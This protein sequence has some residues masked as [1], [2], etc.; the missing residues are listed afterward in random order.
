MEGRTEGF[1]LVFAALDL[2]RVRLVHAGR[3]AVL[4]RR[5]LAR[6]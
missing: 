5:V 3:A 4:A 1:E 6:E 2:D